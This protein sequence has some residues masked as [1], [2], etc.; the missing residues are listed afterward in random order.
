MG[1][2]PNAAT[3]MTLV[4]RILVDHAYWMRRI[5]PVTTV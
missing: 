1:E 4:S 3:I 2:T 5:S